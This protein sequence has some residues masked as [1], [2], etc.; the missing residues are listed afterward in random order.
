[1]GLD[2]GAFLAEAAG[3]PRRP[4]AELALVRFRAA[5]ADLVRFADA[6]GR[7]LGALGL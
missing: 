5:Q 4:E 6:L 2:L 3:A 7:E 1:V